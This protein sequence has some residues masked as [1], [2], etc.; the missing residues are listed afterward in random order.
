MWPQCNWK[1]INIVS[2]LLKREVL[3]SISRKM[4]CNFELLIV[5]DKNLIFAVASIYTFSS[6]IPFWLTEITYSQLKVIHFQFW[7]LGTKG[8]QRPTSQ[9]TGLFWRYS[10]YPTNAWWLIYFSE[11]YTFILWIQIPS[12]IS[13]NFFLSW[14]AQWCKYSSF[15][16]SISPWHLQFGLSLYFPKYL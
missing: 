1:I 13:A 10:S 14:L 15:C 6:M 11:R 4:N 5:F 9:R 8:F 12:N 2:F 3:Y 7:V 16:I